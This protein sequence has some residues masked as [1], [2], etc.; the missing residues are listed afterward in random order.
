MERSENRGCLSSKANL[1]RTAKQ[2]RRASARRL[3]ASVFGLLR[4]FCAL[5]FC[6]LHLGGLELLLHAGKTVGID[7]GCNGLVPFGQGTLPMNC[8]KLEA[9]S[10]L[11][12]VAEVILHSRIATD[13]LRRFH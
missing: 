2:K 8:G 10:A 1:G 3:H 13:P 9:S 7:F 4:F 11:I 6:Q 5:L 12:E